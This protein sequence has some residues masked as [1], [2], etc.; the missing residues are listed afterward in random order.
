MLSVNLSANQF[1]QQPDLI[2]KVLDETGL[3]PKT[4]Q[5]EITERTLMYDAEFALGVL[6]KLKDL[7]VKPRACLRTTH[8][9][10][11]AKLPQW[12]NGTNSTSGN[13]NSFAISFLPRKPPDASG[14]TRGRC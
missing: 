11:A 5:V 6:K 13:G 9:G 7:G 14:V 1:V 10:S 4:L 3:E 12:K 8:S 2:P